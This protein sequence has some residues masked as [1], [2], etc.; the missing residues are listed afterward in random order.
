MLQCR[1][2]GAEIIFVKMK[3]GRN[4]PCDPALVPFW[5]NPNAKGGAVTREG[6]MIPCDFEGPMDEMTDVGYISHFATC[7]H[8]DLFRKGKK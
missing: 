8:A 7:P 6:D 1:A 4:M 5:A 2:C 3:T